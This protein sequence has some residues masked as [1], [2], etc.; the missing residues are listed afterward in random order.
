MRQKQI[1]RVSIN[2]NKTSRRGGT[3]QHKTG[4]F[5]SSVCDYGMYDLLISRERLTQLPVVFLSRIS[6][7]DLNSTLCQY[8]K[9]KNKTNTWLLKHTEMKNRRIDLQVPN[10]TT[11]MSCG[12]LQRKQHR[13]ESNIW[14]AASSQNEQG[15][16]NRALVNNVVQDEGGWLSGL[17][18]RLLQVCCSP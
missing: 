6:F 8:S 9:V 18:A 16:E 2:A 12:Q 5:S 11:N 10:T 4:A 13:H 14:D 15:R 17:K 1:W 7:C 3:W